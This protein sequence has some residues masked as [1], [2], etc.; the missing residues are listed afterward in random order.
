VKT[1]SRILVLACITIG[2][3]TPRIEDALAPSQYRKAAKPHELCAPE[4]ELVRA[5]SLAKR[6]YREVANLSATCYPGVPS[7]CERQLLDR[8]CELRA[9][10][11]ILTES[12][13]GGTPMGGTKDS[14]VAQSAIAVKWTTP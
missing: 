2:C 7:V 12:Q 8:A 9:H 11:I 14:R 3:A 10:A 6:P 5:P 13:A 4:V 1:L